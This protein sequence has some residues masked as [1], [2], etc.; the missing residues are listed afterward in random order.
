[1]NRFP[2]PIAKCKRG[3]NK[4]PVKLAAVL[5]GVAAECFLGPGLTLA[6]PLSPHLARRSK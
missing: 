5:T 4:E 6:Y 2:A 1:M 3:A